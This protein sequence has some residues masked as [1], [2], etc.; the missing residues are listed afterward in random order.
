MSLQHNIG[1]FLVIIDFADYIQTCS[2]IF[3][4]QLWVILVTETTN[5][6]VHKKCMNDQ[7]SGSDLGEP[8]VLN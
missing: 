7:M 6:F 1:Q 4:W 5:L 2:F 3:T 8:L